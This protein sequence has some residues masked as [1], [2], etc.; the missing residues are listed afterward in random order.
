MRTG[1]SAEFGMTGGVTV[2]RG[3]LDMFLDVSSMYT[4][5]P[6]KFGIFCEE[7]GYKLEA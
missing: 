4:G 3:T 5:R 6:A 7:R 2:E 1:R